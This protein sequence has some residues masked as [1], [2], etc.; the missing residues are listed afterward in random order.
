MN[1][2]VGQT[3]PPTSHKHGHIHIRHGRQFIAA[4]LFGIVLVATVGGLYNWQHSKLDKA[5][6]RNTVLTTQVAMLKS[7][8]TTAS[9]LNNGI[10]PT[11]PA[12]GVAVNE[13]GLVYQIRSPLRCLLDG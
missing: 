13:V 4:Y 8:I 6:K 12:S 5:T 10:V 3:T 7:E 9:D 2:E 11:Q 1:T